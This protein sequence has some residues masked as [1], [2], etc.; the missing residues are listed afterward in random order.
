M[1]RQEW[2]TIR[3]R[4]GETGTNRRADLRQI[5]DIRLEFVGTRTWGEYQLRKGE[6]RACACAWNERIHPINRFA[7]FEITS[8]GIGGF[9]QDTNTRI[10][11]RFHG[12]SIIDRVI[13]SLRNGVS[14]V[15]ACR[16]LLSMSGKRNLLPPECLNRMCQAVVINDKLVDNPGMAKRKPALEFYARPNKSRAIGVSLKEAVR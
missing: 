11:W 10:T 16:Y 4:L 7:T 13:L 15:T 5:T 2:Q 3:Y 14:R 12:L 6:A 8:A 9:F 1:R